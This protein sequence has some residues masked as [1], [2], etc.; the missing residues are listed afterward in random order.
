[1]LV[2][3]FW[4]TTVG[5]STGDFSRTIRDWFQSNLLSSLVSGGVWMRLELSTYTYKQVEQTV[6]SLTT[7]SA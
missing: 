2:P 3:N 7:A 5:P 1:M 6:R 4:T